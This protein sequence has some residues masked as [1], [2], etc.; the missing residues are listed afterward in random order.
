M[1]YN[2]LQ[3]S[4]IKNFQNIKYSKFCNFESLTERMQILSLFYNWNARNANIWSTTFK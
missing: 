3:A 2:T 1:K 4:L